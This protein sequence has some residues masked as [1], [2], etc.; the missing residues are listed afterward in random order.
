MDKRDRRSSGQDE[1]LASRAG[2]GEQV[3]CLQLTGARCHGGHSSA[4]YRDVQDGLQGGVADVDQVKIL[5]EVTPLHPVFSVIFKLQA[6]CSSL[7]NPS[8][9]NIISKL[10]SSVLSLPVNFSTTSHQ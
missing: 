2:G 4:G 6:E 3:V 8:A 5:Y 7:R 1:Q 9:V 10:L